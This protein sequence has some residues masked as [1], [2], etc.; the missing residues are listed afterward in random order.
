MK[1]RYAFNLGRVY[2]LSLAEL[3][4]VFEREKLAFSLVE[5]YREVLVIETER[6]LDCV[7]LQKQ[8]GGTVKIMEVLDEL[9][10]KKDIGPSGVFRDY[11]D[12][13]LLRGKFFN[14]EIAGKITFGVSIY[15]VA[16]E[17]PYLRDENKRV[18]LTIKKILKAAGY[19]ARAVFPQKRALSLPSVTVTNERLLESGAE[20][21][22]LVGLDKIWLAKTLT[23]QDFED[24]GRRDYQRPVR[25]IR[26]GMLPPKV[27]QSMINLAKVPGSLKA[28]S[29]RAI[30]DP[31]AGSGTIIQEA[32]LL[33][34][35]AIGSDA[36]DAQIQSAQTNLEWIRNR[37][38]LPPGKFQI[39]LSDI[40]ELPGKLAKLQITAIVTEGTL[41]PA[42]QHLPKPAEIKQNFADLEPV[43]LEL[44]K[45][46]KKILNPASLVV[47]A[48]P[49]YRLAGSYAFFPI[50]DKIEKL[51][52]DI[53]SP[54]P[55]VL[56]ERF[57]FLQVT[58]RKSI[59]YDRKDQFVSREIFIFQI[60]D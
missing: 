59:I 32:M 58:E 39:I 47:I 10:R 3:F 49:A 16:R 52:Y 33:G 41:G 26:V 48:L 34:Y 11:F 1:K 53:L 36:N 50:V 42:Y 57:D 46:A 31:F 14:P 43:Y 6:E 24:Y 30:L 54:L 13:K 5:L 38:S 8:L 56:L 35:K 40:R 29:T 19:S 37:Y 18:G 17:M 7:L 22:F 60:A 20:I 15:Q 55:A 44:F 2:T 51:G 4:A 28:D 9:S 12:I 23:V 25:N 45:S 21:D 27:A